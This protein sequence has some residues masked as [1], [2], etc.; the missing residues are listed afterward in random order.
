MRFFGFVVPLPGI[1]TRAIV[2]R[3][4][5]FRNP[6][7]VLGF[8]QS[9]GRRILLSEQPSKRTTTNYYTRYCFRLVSVYGTINPNPKVWKAA[10]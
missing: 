9:A 1:S 2:V 10:P 8:R 3:Y 7:F 6:A 4:G 5:E